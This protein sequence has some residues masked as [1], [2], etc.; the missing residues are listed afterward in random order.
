MVHADKTRQE[1][2]TRKLATPCPDKKGWATV[3]MEYHP[4]YTPGR[5]QVETVSGVLQ[6]VNIL[7][8]DNE[9]LFLV[10]K[11][12]TVYMSPHKE[13]LESFM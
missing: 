7:G 13:A 6:A 11:Q 8:E 1:L 9:P 3:E 5:I 4:A 2:P 12:G 10:Y